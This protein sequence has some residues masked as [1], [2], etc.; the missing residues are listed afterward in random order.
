MTLKQEQAI[1]RS[2][3]QV[4]KTGNINLLTK[5]AYKFIMLANGFIAHYDIHGFRDVYKDIGDFSH[6]I[7]RNRENN[8]WSNFRPGD[9]NYEY[10]MQ[11]KRIYNAICD[12]PGVIAANFN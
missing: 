2:F 9:Q 5:D 7:I 8:Q 11:E 6:A 1:L 3:S 4:F 10:M 12:M